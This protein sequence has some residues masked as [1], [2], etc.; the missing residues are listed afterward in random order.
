MLLSGKGWESR[1]LIPVSSWKLT[2]VPS[3]HV[4]SFSACIFSSLC[5]SY[6]SYFSWWDHFLGLWS[7]ISILSCFLSD[8]L[9]LEDPALCFL[10]NICKG[11]DFSVSW[12]ALVLFSS[13]IMKSAEE[14]PR[15]A[16]FLVSFLA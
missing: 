12:S 3:L 4:M 7:K 9:P 16:A 8:C 14:S 1:S 6:D 13:K 11:R 10:N 15:R 2:G 5:F